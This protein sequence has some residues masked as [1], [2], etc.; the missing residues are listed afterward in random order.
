MTICSSQDDFMNHLN[1]LRQELISRDY[2]P[3]IV[4]QAFEKLVKIERKEALKKV[5][6][7][8]TSREVMVVTFHPGLPSVTKI[9]KKHWKVMTNRCPKLKRCFAAPS[10]VAYKR[11][12]NLQEELVRAKLPAKRSSRKKN[13]FTHCNRACMACI[14]CERTTSHKCQRTGRSWLIST[15]LNC[16]SAN[17]IYKIG[18]RKCPFFV[19]IGETERKFSERLTDHRGYV[20]RHTDHAIGRH[21]NLAG[22]DVTD[23]VPVPIEKIFPS[24]NESIDRIRKRREKY[25]IQMYDSTSF[26]GANTRE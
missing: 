9:I 22:H 24:A 2:F 7:K 6:R 5:E 25:W 21:F 16:E 17:V 12:K 1:T 10:M 20:N 13:G 18:C 19:Y 8:A 23:M 26:E 3:K 11:P 4:D 14:Q 15:P